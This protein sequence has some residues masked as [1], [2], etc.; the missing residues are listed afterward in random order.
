M[1]ENAASSPY[2]LRQER[3][4]HAIDA[5]GFDALALN[6]GPSLIY[7]SGLHFHLMERPVI[8]L[9]APGR[10]PRLILPELEVGKTSG[11]PFPL[12]YHTY[13]EDPQ[14]W[15]NTFAQAMSALRL[16]KD[17]RIGV[18]PRSLR[19]LELRLLEYAAPNASFI[20]A[21]DLIAG[22]RIAKDPAEIAAMRRAVQIAQNALLATL[23]SI[24]IGVTERELASELT[25]QLLRGGAESKL[26]FAPIVC[27][28]S[29]SA[30]PHAV[31]GE[32][33]LQAGDLLIIDWGAIHEGYLSDLTRTFAIGEI[34]LENTRIA[35]VVAEANQAGRD[36]A[37][38]GVPASM[39][40]SATRQIIEK[41]G[42]GPYFIHRTGHGLGMEEHEEPY[43]RSGN[44]QLLSPG[45]TFTVEPGIYL[46]ESGGVRIEDD[47]V[48]TETGSESLSNLPRE[49]KII[50]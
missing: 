12:E 34:S 15:G 24:K 28:G 29:N 25:V 32:R 20:S 11:L 14:S 48:I 35:Q 19:V 1:P 26:P 44:T 8:L 22:L 39:V 38:P 37:A 10:T 41:A 49:I 23:P 18:E 6:P 45:M 16:K 46:P 36:A 43:I 17:A 21:E 47:V 27:A 9:F 7:L 50:G 3:L 33:R 5:A 2:P 42:Y 40:D 13:G 31:P 30:N 4:T